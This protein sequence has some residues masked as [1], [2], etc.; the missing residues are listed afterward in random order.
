MYLRSSAQSSA[1]VL[2]PRGSG[3][4]QTPT[5][6]LPSAGGAQSSQR[7]SVFSGNAQQ[8]NPV[9]KMKEA[10]KWNKPRADWKEA[11]PS[12]GEFKETEKQKKIGGLCVLVTRFL[13]SVQT[14]KDIFK[15]T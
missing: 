7:C 12:A 4:A 9:D 13:I 3:D 14:R 8:I 2:R 5:R 15:S 6:H 1:C 10:E 11:L